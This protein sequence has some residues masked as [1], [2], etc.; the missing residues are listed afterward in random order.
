MT[1]EA[2]FQTDPPGIWGVDS[3]AGHWH[4]RNQ[5]TG[6]TKIIGPVTPARTKQRVNYFDRAMAEATRRN[7]GSPELK[8]ALGHLLNPDVA[9]VNAGYRASGGVLRSAHEPDSALNCASL[10]TLPP[11]PDSGWPFPSLARASCP[12][13]TLCRAGDA[14]GGWCRKG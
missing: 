7:A 9:E 10:V 12:D 1:N 2:A 8:S 4:I 13:P 11:H 6:R 14:C 3:T 5:Q